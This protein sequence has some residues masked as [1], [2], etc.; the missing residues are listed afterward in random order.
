[1]LATVHIILISPTASKG[2]LTMLAAVHIIVDERRSLPFTPG[3]EWF[4]EFASAAAAAVERLT[5]HMY[6]LG[7]GP[8]LTL[9]SYLSPASLDRCGQGVRALQ[10]RLPREKRGV[11][12]AG[13]T[14]AANQGG[15]SGINEPW[16]NRCWLPVHIIGD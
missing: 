11:L 6:S 2:G 3:V 7:N 14:A 5:F 4:G 12:W 1:M 8:K 10:A 16:I 13:E 9:G 15:A